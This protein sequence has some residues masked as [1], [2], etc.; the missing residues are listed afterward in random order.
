MAKQELADLIG[1]RDLEEV[2]GEYFEIF[3]A[4]GRPLF[5]KTTLDPNLQSQALKWVNSSGALKA[6]LVVLDPATGRVLALA[7]SGNPEF[8]AAL[9]S[10]FPA[11]SIFKIV[12]AAAAMEMADYNSMTSIAYDGSQHT[13]YKANLAKGPDQGAHSSTLRESFA[14]SINSVFGK[15]GAFSL[16]PNQLE[17]MATS[18]GFNESLD[19]ELPLA[20]SYFE[21]GENPDDSFRLAE[22]ASG[23][24]RDTRLSPVHGALIASMALN[25]GDLFEP[26]IISQVSDLE[27]QV[28]YRGRPKVLTHAI[29]LQTSEELS[30]MMQAAVTEGTGRKHFSD[31]KTNPVLSKLILGGKSGTINDETG[32]KV[33]WFVAFAAPSDDQGDDQ[34]HDNADGP[35][36]EPIDGHA[37]DQIDPI[38]QN[39]QSPSL[40]LAAVIVH[41]GK[42]NFASQELIRKALLAYYSP[43]L[44]PKD[45][46]KAKAKAKVM[47]G[48]KTKPS[49]GRS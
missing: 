47:A 49:P 38:A 3:D 28:V 18:F 4:N 25:G 44:N 11:A 27:D 14:K 33:D 34:G 29:S 23:F 6:A 35:G 41:D 43:L 30:L 7:G 5:V 2:A 12:T 22:L 24:N 13:L 42:T 19:F 21:L 16:G 8:N 17:E 36:H 31:A 48:Q 32:A 40:A 37:D 39:P 15:L 10:S 46:A 9:E 1:P 45:P 26:T 20:S